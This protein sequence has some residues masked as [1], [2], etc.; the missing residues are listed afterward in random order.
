MGEQGCAVALLTLL[1]FACVFWLAVPVASLVLVAIYL[2]IYLQ[3]LYRQLPAAPPPGPAQAGNQAGGQPAYRQYFFGQAMADLANVTIITR[4][5]CRS[6][7]Q[8]M[9]H[10]I[11]IFFFFRASAMVAALR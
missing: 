3:V 2:G 4:R 10:W 9:E 5:R 7:S 6:R 1:L 8:H 11:A